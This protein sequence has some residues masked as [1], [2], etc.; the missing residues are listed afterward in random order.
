[1]TA[2][3]AK[4]IRGRELPAARG[5]RAL[6]RLSENQIRDQTQQIGNQG[7][8]ERPEQWFHAALFC[9]IV[10]KHRDL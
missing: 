4:D 6:D 9:V 8:D 7:R 3:P 5:A 2:M 1:M 10:D